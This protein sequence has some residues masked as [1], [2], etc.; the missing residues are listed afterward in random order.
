M[1]AVL[2][3]AENAQ[4]SSIAPIMEEI[5]TLGAEAS[6]RRVYGDFTKINLSPWKQVSLENSFRPVNAFSFV[7]GKGSSDAVMIIEAMEVRLP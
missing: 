1:F 3:D 4:H 5:A 2:V 6:V 7:S